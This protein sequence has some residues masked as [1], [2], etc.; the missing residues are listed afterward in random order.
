M[1][2]SST[3]LCAV[4]EARAQLTKRSR[5]RQCGRDDCSVHVP[6]LGCGSGRIRPRP[7]AASRLAPRARTKAVEFGAEGDSWTRQDWARRWNTGAESAQQRLRMSASARKATRRVRPAEVLRRAW[8]IQVRQVAHLFRAKPPSRKRSRSLPA[9]PHGLVRY[10]EGI[11]SKA[12]RSRITIR[13]SDS[14]R[15]RSRSTS[16]S[17]CRTSTL[18]IHTSRPSFAWQSRR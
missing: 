1:N 10:T 2:R 4:A 5:F 13:P 18:T 8:F 3:L 7:R 15:A 11:C 9:A 16:A 14:L 6:D 17:P 12:I